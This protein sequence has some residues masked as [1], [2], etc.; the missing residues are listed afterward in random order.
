M[1]TLILASS[2]L[3]RKEIL[4]K[5]GLR[6]KSFVPKIDESNHSKEPPD[7]FAES[8]ARKKAFA[9]MESSKADKTAW[10]LGADTVIV[11][12][13]EIIGKPKEKEDAR[14]ILLALSGRSHRVVTGYAV[15]PPNG[16]ALSA[17]NSTLVW[18]DR[19]PDLELET[20]LSGT[21][22]KGVAGAYRIQGWASRYISRIEGSYSSVMGLPIRDIYVMLR[23][24][25]FP[26]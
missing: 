20:Y 12:D 9:A 21:E 7:D 23:Q 4:R 11:K 10:I 25:G 1:A 8:L 6:F 19:I 15:I 13:E 3:R 16:E 17:S 26:L 24:S 2:S 22:W 5:M 18:F 14:R